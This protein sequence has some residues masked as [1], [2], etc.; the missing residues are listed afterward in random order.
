MEDKDD[1]Y[2]SDNPRPRKHGD[3]A[4]PPKISI[5]TIRSESDPA[6][7][8]YGKNG[9]LV[10]MLALPVDDALYAGSAR[11]DQTELE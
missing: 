1:D 2:H 8:H 4:L 11:F 9:R 6:F 10:G 3:S 7:F 5:A